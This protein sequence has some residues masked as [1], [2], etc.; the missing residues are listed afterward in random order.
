MFRIGK[1]E[2]EAVARAINSKDFFK[3]NG[4]GQEVYNFENEMKAFTGAQHCILMSSGFG[5][6]TSA[7][8]GLGIGPGDEVIVPAYTYIATALAV[9]AVGAI[10]VIVEADEALTI[11]VAEVEKKITKATKAVMPVHIQGFPCDMD[12]LKALCDKHGIAIV[13][14]AC[15]ADGGTYKGKALGTIGDAGA[16]SFNYYKVITA[17]EGGA[18]VT[19]NKKIFERA[20]IYHDA[21]AV[22][23]FGNQLDDTSEPV[24]GGTEFRVSDIT[25]AIMREQLKKL[26]SIIEDLGK[27]RVSL[28]SQLC[29]KVTVIPSH[30]ENGGC[31]TTLALRF[32]TAEKT[33]DFAKKCE[34]KGLSVVIPINT[35]KHIYTNWTQIMEKRGAIHPAMDPFRMKENEGLQMDYTMDMCPKTLDYLA[36]TAYISIDPDWAD[37]DIARIA[38]I[39]NNAM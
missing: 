2:I 11:D 23:F 20:L 10:P 27:N 15:Q 12:S 35:G 9:T 38:E 4:S 5:A 26:P 25:G 18:L 31:P 16:Y 33:N 3:C 7:L 32:D 22:A 19:D 39:I 17:G 30:D 6:L 29:D 34:E 13:E 14:D 21:S 8:I 1:E 37:E 28:I 36:R 24:F